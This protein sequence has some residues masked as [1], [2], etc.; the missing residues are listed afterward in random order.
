M[1][2][3]NTEHAGLTK[4]YSKLNSNVRSQIFAKEHLYVDSEGK[5]YVCCTCDSA[6]K[7]GKMPCQAVA[8]GL[9]LDGIPGKLNQLT[10]LERQLLATRI[11]F[12]KLI[13][14]PRGRQRSLHGPFVNV[15][16][17][18]DHVCSLP[19]R[20]PE[21]AGLIRVKLKRQLK[22][23]GHFMHQMVRPDVVKKALNWLLKNNKLYQNVQQ[24]DSWEAD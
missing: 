3:I 7:A 15:P 20:I 13:N 21:T 9:P 24:N 12:M 22:Y 1:K 11:P 2:Q 18:F 14:L 8:N 10:A 23:N 16:A 17:K 19:P 4:R 5:T 6:M